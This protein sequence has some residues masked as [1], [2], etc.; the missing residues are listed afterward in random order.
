MATGRIES[1]RVDIRAPGNVPMQR[2]GV[3]EVNFVG[4]RAEAQGAGQIADALDRMSASLFGEAFRQR[5]KEGLQFAAENPLTPE[6]FE[7]AKNGDLT[8]LQLGNNPVSVFQQAV[9]KARALELS[10][11]FET[12][13]RNELVVLLNQVEQGQATSEQVLT[14]INTMTNGLGRTLAK[15]DPEAAFKFRATMATQGNVV[16]KSAIEAETKREL[17]KQRVL[18]DMNFDNEVRIMEKAAAEDPDNFEAHAS[19]FRAQVARASVR[20]N[21]P[22]IQAQYSTKAEEALKK[23]RVGAVSAFVGSTDFSGDPLAAIKRL[24]AMDAGKMS[25]LWVGMSFEEKAQVRSN[26]R[27]LVTERQSAVDQA[28]KDALQADAVQVAQLETQYFQT[29]SKAALDKLRAISIRN[30]KAISPERVFDL[31]QKRAGGEQ[32]NPRAEFVLKTEIMQGLHPDP[33]SIEKR[34]KEL[35]I[36]YKRLNEGVLSFYISRTSEEER[37]IDRLFRTESKIIPGQFNIS[38]RQNEAYASLER[39]FQREY[40]AAV[41]AARKDNKPLPTKMQIADKVVKGRRDSEANKTIQRLVDNLNT[42]Y[43]SNGSVRK[44]GVL[45]TDDMDVND[46]A[47]RA[48]ALGLR[49]EDVDAIRQSYRAISEQRK[50]LDAE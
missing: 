28:A 24:D 34:A 19:L 45:F 30:P 29:G 14:K 22:A 3:Q 46:I 10:N 37:D 9:Q 49:R 42:N 2:V 17:N 26:L 11:R 27:T 36:G 33:S 35:G 38:Q 39:R 48:D 47:S 50:K 20:L 15:V 44:T 1:G 40:A 7:A 21:D 8:T 43:G 12:E 41:E 6:Q 32:A 23:A 16:L 5:E 13:G 4:S 18:F 31:P 25:K